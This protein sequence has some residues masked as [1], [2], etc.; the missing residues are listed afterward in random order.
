MSPRH[1]SPARLLAHAL[2]APPIFE[3]VT[4]FSEAVYI[5]NFTL[6]VRCCSTPRPPVGAEATPLPRPTL[7]LSG[8]ALPCQQWRT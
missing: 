8:E 6:S 3:V 2:A 7:Q 1:A 5:G 4:F